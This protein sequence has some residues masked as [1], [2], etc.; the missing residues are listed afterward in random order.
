MAD[1]GMTLKNVASA[2]KVN[3][4][5]LKQNLTGYLS[6][7]MTSNKDT[8]VDAINELF[9]FMIDFKT[10]MAEAILKRGGG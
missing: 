6:S 5:E 1:S 4:Q 7:L 2:I 8:L 9:S 10:A 3:N